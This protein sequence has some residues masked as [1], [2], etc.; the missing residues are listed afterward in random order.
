MSERA[1]RGSPRDYLELVRVFLSPSAVADSL[2]GLALAAGIG[3]VRV[4]LATAAPLAAAS[5]AAYWFGMATNDWFDLQ[6]DRRAAPGRP[7]PS[8]RISRRGAGTLCAL[9]LAASIGAAA[10]ATAALHAVALIALILLYNGGGKRVPLLGAALMGGC[11]SAN[12]LL[13]AAAGGGETWMTR[14]S[15]LAAAALGAYIAGVTSVSRLEDSRPRSRPILWRGLALLA[16]PGA[17]VAVGAGDPYALGAG[18]V[19]FAVLLQALRASVGPVRAR[20]SLHPAAIFV[21]Q[22]LPGLFWVDAGVLAALSPP[23]PDRSWALAALVALW[24]AGWLWR[25][26][27]IRAGS[28]GS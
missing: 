18:V 26:R 11:R 7:L 8:G 1:R 28:M 3:G 10:L 4:E 15:L 24:A 13:G 16:V 19:L 5:L 21:R 22:A 2:A 9:L 23:G 27:W 17:I 6:K 12:F 14:P 20:A 25:R